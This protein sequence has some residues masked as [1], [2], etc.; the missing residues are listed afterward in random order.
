M[1]MQRSRPSIVLRARGRLRGAVAPFFFRDNLKSKVLRGNAWLG[2][3]SVGSQFTRFVRN[4]ILARL[5]APEAFGTMAIVISISTILHSMTDIGMKDALVQNPRGSEDHYANAAWLLA[6]GRSLLLYGIL[7]SLAPWLAGFYGNPVVSPLLR[8]CALGLIFDG[9]FSPKAWV[10]LKEMK[11]KKWAA[12]I[13]GGGICGVVIT[14]VLAFFIRDVWALAIGSVA[15]S[16]CAFVLSYILCPHIP[17]ISWDRE[18][19]RDLLV[20]VK[21]LVGLSFLNFIF[22]RT[23]VFVLGKLFHP[24]E[25]GL[26]VMAVFLV[27]TPMS[28][29]MNMFGQTLL[30]AFSHVQQDSTRINRNF[31]RLT[32]VLAA[33]AMPAL[34]F[35]LFCGRSLLTFF[36]GHRYAAAAPALMVA[37]FVAVINIVNGNITTVFYAKGVPQLHRR[38]VAIMALT[39][40]VLIYPFA[41]TFGLVGGQLAALA[42]ILVG[43]FSQVI[44]MREVTGLDL[45][46]YIKLF[47]MPV[48]IASALALVLLAAQ[49]FVLGWPIFN[50]SLGVVGCAAAYAFGFRGVVRRYQKEI[51]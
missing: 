19:M 38:C 5:L 43:Y 36:Y 33:A 13:H 10:A 24:T 4:I 31:L 50:I 1:E 35:I 23:D 22:A 2:T 9:A 42:S 45:K 16:A 40:I 21:G 44:R 28:F 3:W 39:M 29:I 48:A 37:A 14:I 46:R 41:K 17:S 34:V 26:Y 12:I 47:A 8:V 18:A 15:Q 7:F 49:P 32:G 27:Q 30:P 25:L 51:A 20:F 11:F 6:I